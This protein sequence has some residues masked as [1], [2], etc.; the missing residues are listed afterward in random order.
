MQMPDGTLLAR[1]KGT[2]QGSPI[3]PLELRSLA[4][5]IDAHILRW[6]MQSSN[7]GGASSPRHKRGWRESHPPALAEPYVTVSRH[8]APTGRPR[9]GGERRY[10]WAKSRGR[11]LSYSPSTPRS[12]GRL[13]SEAHTRDRYTIRSYVS[14]AVKH[15]QNALA[16]LRDAMLGRPW[17][18]ALPA[19]T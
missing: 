13:T 12:T 11:R 17:L 18:P 4:R 3:S 16:V 2:P 10:Q 9:V 19:P 8:T 5:H 1:E 6:A 15:G 7:D 14:T